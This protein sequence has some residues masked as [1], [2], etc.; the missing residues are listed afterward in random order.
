M[1][2]LTAQIVNSDQLIDVWT[3]DNVVTVFPIAVPPLPS[4]VVEKAELQPPKTRSKRKSGDLEILDT[5]IDDDISATAQSGNTSKK[6]CASDGSEEITVGLMPRDLQSNNTSA[7]E[8]LI[9]QLETEILDRES[10]GKPTDD[11]KS[12]RTT[13]MSPI[14]EDRASPLKVNRSITHSGSH[15]NISHRS[16]FDPPRVLGRPLSPVRSYGSLNNIPPKSSMRPIK[17]A[18]DLLGLIHR[19][20]DEKKTSPLDLTPALVLPA[21]SQAQSPSPKQRKT[22]GNSGNGNRSTRDPG[23][24]PVPPLPA[25]FASLNKNKSVTG[26][27]KEEKERLLSPAVGKENRV[28]NIKSKKDLPVGSP[29]AGLKEFEWPEDCF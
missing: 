7:S 28:D 19:D 26:L 25:E 11:Y 13:P 4:P 9:A 6:R 3:R 27:V 22:G 20:E 8:Q 14:P 23:I 17:S 21:P 2:D 5:E 12:P 16:D 1:P 24:P 10:S 15:T 18:R 29:K